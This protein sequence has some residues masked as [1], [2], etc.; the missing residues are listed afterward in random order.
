M[1]SVEYVAHLGGIVLIHLTTHGLN[2]K[3]LAHL[4]WKKNQWLNF[5]KFSH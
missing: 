5:I 4:G 3:F 1:G 2:E